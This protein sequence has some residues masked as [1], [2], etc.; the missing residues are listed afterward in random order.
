MLICGLFA[1][2]VCSDDQLAAVHPSAYPQYPEVE[3]PQ[4]SRLFVI[5]KMS[6]TD[7]YRNAFNTLW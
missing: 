2:K 3:G 6:G 5:H 1:L 4:V 7:V